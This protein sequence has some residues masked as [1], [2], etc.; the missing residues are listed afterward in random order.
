[1]SSA[2]EVRPRWWSWRGRMSQG[3]CLL[4]KLALIGIFADSFYVSLFLGL[5]MTLPLAYCGLVSDMR[6]FHDLDLSGWHLLAFY[7]IQ[8]VSSVCIVAFLLSG[9]SG[10]EVTGSAGNYIVVNKSAWTITNYLKVIEENGWLKWVL[11]FVN[12]VVFFFTDGTEGPNKYGP[13]PMARSDGNIFRTIVVA[14]FAVQGVVLVVYPPW[15]IKAVSIF[16]AGFSGCLVAFSLMCFVVPVLLLTSCV[17]DVR[18]FRVLDSLGRGRLLF[19]ICEVVFR[20]FVLWFVY[21]HG[22]E[23]LKMLLCPLG[24]IDYLI[25]MKFRNRDVGEPSEPTMSE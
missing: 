17:T 23:L 24:I 25:Y 14:F 12:L 19:R 15:W 13:N 9:R 10:L 16:F 20:G 6:R 8:V 3:E 1:M 21:A 11:V 22:S 7:T 18:R 2:Y 4:F 5:V